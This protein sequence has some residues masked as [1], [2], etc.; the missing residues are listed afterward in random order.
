MK[1]T[2]KVNQGLGIASLVSDSG[3]SVSTKPMV[4]GAKSATLM[5]YTSARYSRS[6]DGIEYIHD[7][8]TRKATDTSARL[9][10]IVGEYGHGSVAALAPI[11]VYLENIPIYLAARIHYLLEPAYMSQEASTRYIDFSKPSFHPGFAD[12]KTVEL[13]IGNYKRLVEPTKKYLVEKFN[14]N[15]ENKAHRIALKARAFDCLRYLLPSSINTS[16]SLRTDARVLSSLISLLKD[17]Y[18]IEYELGSM[19]YELMMGNAELSDLGYVPEIDSLIRHTEKDTNR[20]SSDIAIL[21]EFK[22]ILNFSLSEE[23]FGGSHSAAYEVKHD[24]DIIKNYLSL[25]YPNQRFD[26][27]LPHLLADKVGQI[28]YRFHSRHRMI[29][30]KAQLGAL[31]IDGK[32]DFGSWRDMNRHRSINKVVPFLEYNAD[33]VVHPDFSICPYLD[34]SHPVGQ[35]YI[36]ALYEHYAHLTRSVSL[37]YRRRNA[38][39]AHNVRYRV[40]GSLDAFAYICELRSRGG[41]HIAYRQI[42]NDWAEQLSKVSWMF[43]GVL[44]NNL[45]TPADPNSISEFLDRS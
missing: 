39:L 28:L 26:I 34:D 13:A 17:G 18:G 6:S 30:N 15:M 10:T 24:A 5:A 40:S 16:M 14:L 45:I 1:F 12:P 38:P 36:D 22:S 43:H 29:G 7:Q 32:M 9:S 4:W 42:A 19:L 44:K 11:T 20:Y 25:L 21:Q 35:R 23:L 8:V 37:K 27:A 2:A 41:G 31:M 33:Q 3:M